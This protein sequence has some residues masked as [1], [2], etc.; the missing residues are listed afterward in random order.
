ML[1]EFINGAGANCGCINLHNISNRC[2]NV[3]VCLRDA[4]AG[5]DGATAGEGTIPTAI[6]V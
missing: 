1:E 6:N 4:Q 3:V 5:E 2:I